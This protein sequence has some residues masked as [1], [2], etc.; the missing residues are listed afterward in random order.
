MY[1]TTIAPNFEIQCVGVAVAERPE[2]PYKDT[3]PGP[4]VCEADQG[5]SID[6]S[7]FLAADG[8]AYLYWKNDGNAV[9][10]D[11]WISVQRLARDGT[12]LVGERR[13][14]LKQDL[15]WEG[16]LVEGPSVWERDGVF[17]LFYSANDFGSDRYAVGHATASSPLGP[18][19]KDPDPVLVSNEVA[20]GPGH[21]SLVEKDGRV[22]MVYHAW[23]PDAVGSDVPGRTMWL[24]EVT[25]DGRSVRVDPPTATVGKRP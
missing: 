3:R 8:T 11:T 4:L 10:V 16:H 19:T 18:F 22:W 21:C 23:A 25:F 9:G 5:G 2:G 6:A 12:S 1:Y 15:P 20:A 7:P 14:L 13:R 17:H 24:S